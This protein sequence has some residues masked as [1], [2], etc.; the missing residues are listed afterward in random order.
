M[1]RSRLK[2]YYQ[3][4]SGRRLSLQ[5]FVDPCRLLQCAVQLIRLLDIDSITEILRLAIELNMAGCDVRI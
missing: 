1:P 3:G 5:T 2:G 4:L